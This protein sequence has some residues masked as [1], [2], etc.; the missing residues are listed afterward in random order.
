MVRMSRLRH[1]DFYAIVI[2]DPVP[3]NTNVFV[4]IYSGVIATVEIYFGSFAGF[5]PTKYNLEVCNY[6]GD[7]L[8]LPIC[9]HIAVALTLN[10]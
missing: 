9:L 3:N 4:R 1:T 10:P 8:L 7:N 2:Q 6:Y 5:H